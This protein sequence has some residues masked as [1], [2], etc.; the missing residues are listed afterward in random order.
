MSTCQVKYNPNI[1]VIGTIKSQQ[2]SYIGSGLVK[3]AQTEK[4]L[5]QRTNKGVQLHEGHF[6][7][8]CII[9]LGK[10]LLVT[11]KAAQYTKR[12]NFPADKKLMKLNNQQCSTF[13]NWLE[14]KI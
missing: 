3:I 1:N 10:L 6:V 12:Y 9:L 14:T 4:L 7:S 2:H 5:T 13:N 11:E 8:R